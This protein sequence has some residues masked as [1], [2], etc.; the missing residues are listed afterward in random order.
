MHNSYLYKY[1]IF[2]LIGGLRWSD[3][4]GKGKPPISTQ[5]KLPSLSDP[6][7]P[8]DL[9]TVRIYDSIIIWKKK[10]AWQKNK[11]TGSINYLHLEKNYMFFSQSPGTDASASLRRCPCG[12]I[13]ISDTWRTGFRKS[14]RA[15]AEG[16]RHTRGAAF[17]KIT[18]NFLQPT[19]EG[20]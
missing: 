5:Y 18:F 12:L 10:Q 3:F 20:R 6:E 8:D 1:R 19:S 14:E 16:I 13:E 2:T 7:K 15:G 11:L 9:G 17:P 4:Q